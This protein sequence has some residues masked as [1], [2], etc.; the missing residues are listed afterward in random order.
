MF[1]VGL[2]KDKS[3]C[4]EGTHYSFAEILQSVSFAVFFQAEDGIR[5][6]VRSRGLGAWLGFSFARGGAF[7][8]SSLGARWKEGGDG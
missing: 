3:N 4:H 1:T 5:D 2:G 6:L 7:C 8:G